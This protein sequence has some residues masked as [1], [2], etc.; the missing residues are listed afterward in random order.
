MI[1]GDAQESV[2]IFGFSRQIQN[3]RFLV[4]VS[5]QTFLNPIGAGN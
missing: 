1:V 5:A 2:S 4:F 3:R